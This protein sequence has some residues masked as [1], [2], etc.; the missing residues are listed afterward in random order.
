M[1]FVDVLGIH[2]SRTLHVNL[3]LNVNLVIWYFDHGDA[4]EMHDKI[5]LF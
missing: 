2:A 4:I 5:N 3:I 1:L